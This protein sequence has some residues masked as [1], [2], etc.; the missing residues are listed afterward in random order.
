MAKLVKGLPDSALPN[1]LPKVEPKPFAPA[2]F[3]LAKG[4][5]AAPAPP[6]VKVGAATGAAAGGL[7]GDKL[8]KG[9]ADEADPPKTLPFDESPR[10]PNGEALEAA[11]LANPEVAN[12]AADVPFFSSLTEAS[13]VA[14]VVSVVAVSVFL[15]SAV[16]GE[17]AYA[18]EKPD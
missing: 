11:S 1:P 13:D 5:D 14:G 10:A 12:A 16:T 3:A 2:G 8:P 7:E 17:G 4:N 6:K 9:D 15:V 18:D